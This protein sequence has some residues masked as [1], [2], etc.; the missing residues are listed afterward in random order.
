MRLAATSVLTL[1]AQVMR[2]LPRLNE[3]IN[4]EWI[5]DKARYAIDG[6]RR[7]RLDKPFQRGRDGRLHPVSWDEAL[8]SLATALRKATK[9]HCGHC[10]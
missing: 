9:S 2:V 5:S 8:K 4:E 6:L 7:Q 1:G 10:R 3:D